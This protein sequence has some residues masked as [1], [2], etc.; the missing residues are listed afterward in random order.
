MTPRVAKVKSATQNRSQ[1]AQPYVKPVPDLGN[2]QAFL[3]SDPVF[4]DGKCDPCG[5]SA[6]ST[7]SD[8]HQSSLARS[9][10]QVDP[11]DARKTLRKEVAAVLASKWQ[12]DP[13][14]VQTTAAESAASS[15]QGLGP[16]ETKWILDTKVSAFKAFMGNFQANQIEA[17]RLMGWVDNSDCNDLLDEMDQM[18]ID[19]ELDQF[20]DNEAVLHSRGAPEAA[21]LNSEHCEDEGYVN[22]VSDTG[23]SALSPLPETRLSDTSTLTSLDAKDSGVYMEEDFATEF[24]KKSPLQPA[25]GDHGTWSTEPEE[26]TVQDSVEAYEQSFQPVSASELYTPFDFEDF[27]TPDDE[28]FSSY[29]FSDSLVCK[30]TGKANTS[31]WVKD[32]RLE[33]LVGSEMAT[34]FGE[35]L[36]QNG[37]GSVHEFPAIAEVADKAGSAASSWVGLEKAIGHKSIESIDFSDGIGSTPASYHSALSETRNSLPLLQSGQCSPSLAGMNSKDAHPAPVYFQVQPLEFQTNTAATQTETSLSN[38]KLTTPPSTPPYLTSPDTYEEYSSSTDPLSTTTTGWKIANPLSSNSVAPRSGESFLHTSKNHTVWPSTEPPSPS[39]APRLTSTSNLL[40]PPKIGDIKN[41]RPSA[42]EWSS[43]ERSEIEVVE[44]VDVGSDT[45]LQQIAENEAHSLAILQKDSCDNSASFKSNETTTISGEPDNPDNGP[46]CAKF[47]S[48]TKAKANPSDSTTGEK[49][50]AKRTS[51]RKTVENN[52]KPSGVQNAPNN[53]GESN[54]IGALDNK[55]AE[56]GAGKASLANPK[57]RK[58]RSLTGKVQPTKPAP[59]KGR[60]QRP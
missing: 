15:Y 41:R 40:K 57:K 20:Y 30:I 34:A 24:S 2:V 7:V 3:S 12:F 36:P 32:Q 13:R 16:A 14:K 29:P 39:P 47:V 46:H 25:F 9:C 23:T 54:N 51:R 26:S 50:K 60:G 11:E 35:E 59:K 8:N 31:L 17:R 58:I 45:C 49:V 4:E 52:R 33:P 19:H 42:L 1:N 28:R 43:N 5:P 38:P 6:D 22:E 55:N 44:A 56:L 48:P 10:P 27:I 53:E 21:L 37:C 18:D